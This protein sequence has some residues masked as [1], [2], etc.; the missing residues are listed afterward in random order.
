MIFKESYGGRRGGRVKRIT[1]GLEI[2]SHDQM[3]THYMVSIKKAHGCDVAK[4][5]LWNKYCEEYNHQCGG[6]LVAPDMVI[7]NCH[8]MMYETYK[9]GGVR[10]P[11]LNPSFDE[12]TSTTTEDTKEPLQEFYFEIEP[13]HPIYNL[14][15]LWMGGVDIDELLQRQFAKTFFPH[16][17][18]NYR[19]YFVIGGENTTLKDKLWDFKR[20]QF[21][22]GLIRTWESFTINKDVKLVPL[23]LGDELMNFH[24]TVVRNMHV[25][26]LTGY[27]Q[28][29]YGFRAWRLRYSFRQMQCTSLCQ[30]T[31]SDVHE[32]EICA[33]SVARPD[34]RKPSSSP[35]HGD[36]GSPIVCRYKDK[37]VLFSVH[38]Q[39]LDDKFEFKINA[40]VSISV[41]LACVKHLITPENM[42]YL[43]EIDNQKYPEKFYKLDQAAMGPFGEE[44][45]TNDNRRV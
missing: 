15:T 6:A 10:S 29:E 42:Q 12:W 43:R 36:S 18:C 45:Y 30:L 39:K 28:T 34:Y 3:D 25:C 22:V 20:P 11:P 32:C 5:K 26:L 40:S 38:S 1:N 35:S 2:S 16:S 44:S 17:Q 33:T 24:R 9:V 4:V 8:C 27:G 21:D 7:S 37:N 31:R 14:M 41:A 19:E 23:I 13:R